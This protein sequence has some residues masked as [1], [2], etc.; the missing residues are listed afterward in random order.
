[1]FWVEKLCIAVLACEQEA[2]RLISWQNDTF[3]LFYMC[4]NEGCEESGIQ[5]LEL[6]L[7]NKI[8]WFHKIQILLSRHEWVGFELSI[9]YSYYS[10]NEQLYSFNI[11]LETSLTFSFTCFCSTFTFQKNFIYCILCTSYS[12]AASLP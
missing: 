4:Y 11:E 2:W 7:W 3:C 1:M 10:S 12:S 6:W 5:L 8:L 9:F